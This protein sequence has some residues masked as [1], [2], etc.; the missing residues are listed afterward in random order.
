MLSCSETLLCWAHGALQIHQQH[1]PLTQNHTRGRLQQ[2]PKPIDSH[3]QLPTGGVGTERLWSFPSAGIPSW[4]E[5]REA[6]TKT[7]PNLSLSNTHKTSDR[8]D[9]DGAPME[10]PERWDTILNWPV[11]GNSKPKPIVVHTDK[12]SKRRNGD[13]APMELPERLDTILNWSEGVVDN[14]V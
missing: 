14:L 5:L 9:G 7:D 13:G 8:R 10:F 2:K 6:T 11:W 3:T 1:P 4:T 12:T